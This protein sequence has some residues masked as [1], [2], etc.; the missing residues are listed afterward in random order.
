M[1]DQEEK[2]KTMAY[3][4]FADKLK[5]EQ[6]KGEGDRIKELKRMIKKFE[7]EY[8]TDIK[9]MPTEMQ[10]KYREM[11]REAGLPEISE[12]EFKKIE[13]EGKSDSLIQ[14]ANTI[15]KLGHNRINKTGGI[16]ALSELVMLLRTQTP[17]ND[18]KISKVKK[19]IKKLGKEGLIPGIIKLQSGVEIVEFIPCSLNK[20]QNLILTL[21]AGTGSGSLNLEYIMNRLNWTRER[22]LRVL[23]QLERSNMAK[24]DPSYAEGQKWYFP[25]LISS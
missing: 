9:L 23:E 17:F 6:I 20:D 21:A 4:R 16:I 18:V 7:D 5:M 13:E 24:K 3:K 11:R 15:L 19:V 10:I 1:T 12:V 8:G 25:G 22:V 2:D 14:L